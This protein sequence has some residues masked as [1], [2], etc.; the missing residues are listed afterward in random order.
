MSATTE[1]IRAVGR[2]LVDEG[3]LTPMGQRVLEK[4]LRAEEQADTADYDD[5]PTTAIP[6]DEESN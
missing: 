1:R 6:Y 3:H 4:T 5:I 2:L